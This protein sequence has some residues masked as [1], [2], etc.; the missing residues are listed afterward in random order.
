MLETDLWICAF[1]KF[2]PPCSRRALPPSSRRALWHNSRRAL[3]HPLLALS[4]ARGHVYHTNP[5]V[6]CSGFVQ[7]PLCS[8]VVPT[9]S[10]AEANGC[11]P[12]TETFHHHCL[13]SLSLRTAVAQRTTRHPLVFFVSFTW[14]SRTPAAATAQPHSRTAAQPPPSPPM[15]G[16]SSTK[17]AAAATD[18]FPCRSVR[19]E[20]NNSAR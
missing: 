3:S 16:V 8:D 19:C 7:A 1:S 17:R 9:C 18:K 5:E 2:P 12:S 13:D 10:R 14:T 15:S 4:Q 6:L 11:V 20:F